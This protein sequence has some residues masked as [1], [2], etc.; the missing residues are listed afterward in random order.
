MEA[1]GVSAKMVSDSECSGM[2]LT[3]NS[4]QCRRSTAVLVCVGVDQSSSCRVLR[5]YLQYVWI[6]VLYAADIFVGEAALLC[7]DVM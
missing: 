2:S 7:V 1:S 6:D 5:A 3:I 4:V